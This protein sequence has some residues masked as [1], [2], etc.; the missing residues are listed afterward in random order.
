M[1]WKTKQE[2][3]IVSDWHPWFAWYPI[4]VLNKVCY[5]HITH[6]KTITKKRVWWEYVDRKVTI[7]NHTY[8]EFAPLGTYTKEIV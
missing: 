7:K 4:T 3:R 8:I 6:I 2:F 5:N 1:N